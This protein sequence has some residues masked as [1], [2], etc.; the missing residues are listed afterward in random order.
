MKPLAGTEGGYAIFE[1]PEAAERAYL[2]GKHPRGLPSEQ[3]EALQTSGWLDSLQL[4]W[5]PCA[6]GAELV[7]YGL[8]TLDQENKG[9]RNNARLLRTLLEE[10]EGIE[11]DPEIPETDPAYHLLSF[12]L[13]PS[14]R[15]SPKEAIHRMSKLGLNGFHYIPTPIHQL[16]RLLGKGPS[17][18]WHQQLKQVDLPSE[19]KS[20]P[21]TEAR[22]ASSFEVSWNW[23]QPNPTA[24]EQIAQCLKTLSISS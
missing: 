15:Q 18:F 4:G 16:P 20:L 23:T 7:R 24:M 10:V 2:H 3:A 19:F 5:R 6:V 11:I 13:D 22:C 9:R 1:D 17:V 12:R 21:H 14:L 8:Q